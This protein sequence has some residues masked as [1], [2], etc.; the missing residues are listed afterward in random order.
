VLVLMC[1]MAAARVPTSSPDR[2][3]PKLDSVTTRNVLAASAATWSIRR[4]ACSTVAQRQS[5]STVS[6]NMLPA[7]VSYANAEISYSR[8]VAYKVALKKDLR[9]L[10]TVP[11]VAS[12]PS[13]QEVASISPAALTIEEE[14]EDAML[15][16]GDEEI[17]EPTAMISGDRA[18]WIADEVCVHHN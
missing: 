7:T 17:Y 6:N 4:L 8:I 18:A 2:P 13:R 10:A 12:L 16:C 1:N 15:S 11:P 5:P 14:W 3:F 9:R